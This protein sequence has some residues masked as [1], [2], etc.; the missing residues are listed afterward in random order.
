MW[1]P[2]TEAMAPVNLAATPN[3]SFWTRGDGQTYR[4]MVFAQS[5]GMMPLTKTFAAGAEWSE[6]RFAWSDFGIEGR[7]VIGVVF[8]GGPRPGPFDLRIDQL[9]LR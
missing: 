7:D 1:T 4:I 8:A 6:V 5:K 3:L 2:G 9:R